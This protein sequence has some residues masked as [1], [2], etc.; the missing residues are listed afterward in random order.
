M[1]VVVVVVA[2]AMAV[3]ATATAA[4]VGLTAV[5]SRLDSRLRNGCA[6]LIASLA[7]DDGR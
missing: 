7:S 3:A 4:V 2:P 5:A 6:T 1:G